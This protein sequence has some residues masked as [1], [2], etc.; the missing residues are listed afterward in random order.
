MATAAALV[1]LISGILGA[2]L[3]GY[4][5]F[6]KLRTAR[7]SSVSETTLT[8]SDARSVNGA[9]G[10]KSVL[11]YRA[12]IYLLLSALIYSALQW[13]NGHNEV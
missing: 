4:A 1:S 8:R 7:R 12:A 10:F 6:E 9:G 5:V 3:S 13:F 11:F 2:I